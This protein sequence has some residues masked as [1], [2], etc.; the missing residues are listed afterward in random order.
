[1]R[2]MIHSCP[3]RHWYVE[4]YL[5][6]SMAAQG[7]REEDITVWL[8]AEGR[9]NLLSCMESFKECGRHPGGTWHLQDDAVICRDFAARTM[10]HDDGIVCGFAYAKDVRKRG[11]RKGIVNLQDMWWSFQCI[12][13][14]N[15]VAGECAEWFFTDAVHREKYGRYIRENKHDDMFFRDFLLERY[16]DIKVLNLAPNLT[17]HIDY[18]IGGSVINSDRGYPMTRTAFWA[19]ETVVE[20]LKEKL[21]NDKRARATVFF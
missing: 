2:Y 6:P 3:V 4:D 8:D 15:R 20:E 21:K 1:M 19:D 11:P 18:L 16:G 14:P 13:I 10:E 17:D 12:R 5:V 9:G 7:I